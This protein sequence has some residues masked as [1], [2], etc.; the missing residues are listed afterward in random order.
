MNLPHAR[1]RRERNVRL[2]PVIG[3]AD[4]LSNKPSGQCIETRSICSAQITPPARTLPIDPCSRAAAR[5]GQAG[6][7]EVCPRGGRSR[8]SRACLLGLEGRERPD[9][10]RRH[11]T[12]AC[13]PRWRTDERQ[14]CCILSPSHPLTHH[15][16]HNAL[17]SPPL[18][19]HALAWT[20]NL[21]KGFYITKFLNMLETIKGSIYICSLVIYRTVSL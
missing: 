13:P 3:A 4:P 14:A 7:V 18:V 9:F 2:S 11:S 5:T 19:N 16:S 8:Q 12:S 6:A 15:W 20:L 21:E 10:S 17:P 1:C